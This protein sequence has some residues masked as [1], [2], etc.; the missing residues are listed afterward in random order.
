MPAEIHPTA[1]IAPGA[2]IADNVKIGP[3]AVIDDN[4]YIGEGSV[5][6]AFASIKRFTRIGKN[7]HIHSYA[8]VGGEPQD[9]K[10]HG[11]ESWLE[12]GD[13]NTIREFATLS[14][15]TEGGGGLTRIG[16]N[17][18]LM[19][20]TH[21]AHDCMVDNFIVMSNGATLAGHVHLADGVIMG[22]LSAVHQFCRVGKNAFLG[23]MS[24]ISQDLPPYMLCIGNRDGGV[25]GPNLVGLRRMKV[26][27]ET[28][29]AL[30]Q[31]F[32]TIWLDG[33]PRQQALDELENKFHNVGEVLELI[34]FIRSS[35]RGIM[36][37]ARSDD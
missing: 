28:I 29:A 24:G 15:G 6:D 2:E 5:I 17:N 7:N 35:E 4:V 13:N 37:A 22:G 32:R 23:A 34:S 27:N 21:V 10:F 14:R 20:Y 11:E 8:S 16:N 26:G 25:H 3:C 9:L 1:I 12:I 19:A 18:L 33:Q 30:K 36:P 31:A